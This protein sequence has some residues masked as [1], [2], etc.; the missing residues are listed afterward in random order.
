MATTKPKVKKYKSVYV[1]MLKPNS[2]ESK[3]ILSQTLSSA[4][5]SKKIV[6][7]ISKKL[8]VSFHYDGK[9]GL[10]LIY[11]ANAKKSPYYYVLSIS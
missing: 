7:M 1:S 11:K 6:D 3:K 9:I 4:Q 2:I 5:T 10:Y 8:D